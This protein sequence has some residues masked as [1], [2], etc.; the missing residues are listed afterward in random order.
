M[1][2]DR[3]TTASAWFVVLG[4]ISAALHTAKLAPA[5]PALQRDLGVSLVTSG[6]L[7]SLMLLASALTAVVVGLLVERF[8]LR[9]SQLTGLVLLSAA[10]LAGGFAP[11]EGV[12]LALR[13]VEGIGF[14]L[15]TVPAP[16]L[17]RRLV[18][19]DRLTRTLG[20]WGGFVPIGSAVA[21]LVGAG[22]IAAWGWSGWWWLTAAVS[23]LA[24]ALIAAL[25]PADPPST[26]TASLSAVHRRA[27]ETLG[28]RAPWLLALAFLCYSAQWLGVVGFL[29]SIYSASGWGGTTVAV[30]SALVALSNVAG[31][32]GAGYA[33]H[34]GVRPSTTLLVGYAAMALGA[35]LAFG[36]PTSGTP[37]VQFAGAVVFSTLGGLIP[38]TLF[39]LAPR[40][41]PSEPTI[42]TTVGWMMQLSAVGQLAGPP[43]VAWLATL[44]GGWQLT[45]V[46]TGTASLLGAVL[47]LV[48]GAH[49]AH[50]GVSP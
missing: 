7:L 38:G 34:H 50:R 8:G 35:F 39:A 47:G 16:A 42:S 10:G 22:L 33:L 9:R 30:L 24:A 29:P 43:F 40:L 46:A 36:T 12:L 45:W 31:N 20:V 13:A 49:A 5:I 17:I 14:L 18:S 25:V 2:A 32:I 26:T 41:A 6:V 28:H 23:A 4:G 3:P 11:G 44:A 37:L 19:P 1:T 21:L 48:L 15:A 27:A